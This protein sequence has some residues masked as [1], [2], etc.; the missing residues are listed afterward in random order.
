ME[1]SRNWI[2]S[3]V[4]RECSEL[5]VT[6]DKAALTLS[7]SVKDVMKGEIRPA[8]LK[9]DD[10]EDTSGARMEGSRSRFQPD[11]TKRQRDP[12]A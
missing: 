8:H 2:E 7:R 1:V 5:D 6:L 3:F 9:G 11:N 10:E 4:L 12:V